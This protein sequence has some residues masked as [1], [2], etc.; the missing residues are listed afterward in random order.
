VVKD[1]AAATTRTRLLVPLDTARR[2]KGQRIT[3]L[4][5]A[6]FWRLAG[7]P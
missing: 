5:E 2:L 7:R 6:Q 4:N 3:L 1:L